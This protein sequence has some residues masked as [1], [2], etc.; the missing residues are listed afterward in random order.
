MVRK[1]NPAQLMCISTC[2]T[3]PQDSDIN[4]NGASEI[5]VKVSS[6]STI[7][8]THLQKYPGKRRLLLYLYCTVYFK[9]I[10]KWTR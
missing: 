1:K 9:Y 8:H 2:L 6:S 10:M 7:K 3:A 4:Y 5:D